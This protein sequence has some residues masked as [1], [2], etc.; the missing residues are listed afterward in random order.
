MAERKIAIAIVLLIVLTA[1][2]V[3]FS[4]HQSR[5]LFAQQQK[6]LAELESLE[7]QWGR[8][9]LEEAALTGHG[10]VER[11]AYRELDMFVPS[12]EQMVK[13]Q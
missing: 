13:L 8:L 10:A 2:G 7:S 9:L 1:M 5:L 4:K 11:I 6:A 12:Y 3:V